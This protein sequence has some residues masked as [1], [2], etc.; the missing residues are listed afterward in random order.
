MLVFLDF[1]KLIRMI[2]IEPLI[3]IQAH[4]CP[5]GLSKN[6]PMKCHIEAIKAALAGRQCA[7]AS[8]AREDGALFLR[9]GNP[10]TL[11]ACRRFCGRILTGQLGFA[12]I[13]KLRLIQ[14]SSVSFH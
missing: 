1:S 13:K 3:M 5:T 9:Y 2:M 11:G 10:A 6:K 4:W 7:I 8:A 12:S 14:L